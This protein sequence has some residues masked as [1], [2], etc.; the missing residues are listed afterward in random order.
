M[1]SM[2]FDDDDDDVSDQLAVPHRPVTA[3]SRGSVSLSSQRGVRRRVAWSS[4]CPPPLSTVDDELL[5]SD[6][7]PTIHHSSDVLTHPS[8][9]EQPLLTKNAADFEPEV[10]FEIGDTFEPVTLSD[11]L[12][13]RRAD[14]T[15][16][17]T[18]RTHRVSFAVER[19]EDMALSGSQP[20]VEM[21]DISSYFS[22]PDDSDNEN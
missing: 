9:V 18:T 22:Y 3:K 10:H 2:S 1:F 4:D 16:S 13:E 7:V 17:V 8:H 20:D 14:E 19:R 21:I 11:D 15:V 6:D 5:E 12:G